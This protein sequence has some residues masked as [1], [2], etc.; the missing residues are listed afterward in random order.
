[1]LSMLEP[2]VELTE[3]IKPERMDLNVDI[4]PLMP[5]FTYGN[6]KRYA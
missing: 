5:R 2:R 6:R 4:E 1:M 3:R